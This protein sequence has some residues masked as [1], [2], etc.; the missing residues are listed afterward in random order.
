MAV[1]EEKRKKKKRT[2]KW[3]R[4]R[5]LFHFFIIFFFL[6][7]FFFIIIS[8]PID[9]LI[10]LLLSSRNYNIVQ[11]SD[12]L[13]E[14]SRE[15]IQKKKKKK[16]RRKNRKKKGERRR[17]NPIKNH[18]NDLVPQKRCDQVWCIRIVEIS[19]IPSS[20]IIKSNINCYTLAIHIHT[21]LTCRIYRISF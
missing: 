2:K 3:G 20:L 13:F 12:R 18:I 11:R 9:S 1:K 5:I 16:K 6:F 4:S 14:I 10:V 19:P 21:Y 15:R 7:F 17:S 8:K